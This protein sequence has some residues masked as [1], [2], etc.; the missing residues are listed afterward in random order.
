MK[1]PVRPSAF[2]LCV[3]DE[4]L[5]AVE[6]PL[7][8][9]VV[10]ADARESPG[11]RRPD[12]LRRQPLSLGPGERP[13]ELADAAPLGG[14]A[15]AREELVHRVVNGPGEL[16]PPGHPRV[17]HLMPVHQRPGGQLGDQER[18]VRAGG[19]RL[20]DL[21]GQVRLPEVGAPLAGILR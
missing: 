11:H 5:G 18:R 1:K 8:I 10:I 4:A 2:S 17:D 3:D 19:H 6:Q 7:D 21:T 16:V 9:T 12:D 13:Q 15:E 20:R 14:V